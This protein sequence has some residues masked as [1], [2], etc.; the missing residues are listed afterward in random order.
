MTSDKPASCKRCRC[1]LDREGICHRCAYQMHSSDEC[2]LPAG[3][4]DAI[5]AVSCCKPTPEEARYEP[6]AC[7]AA[8]IVETIEGWAFKHGAR[9]EGGER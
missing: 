8:Q 5:Y 7:V 3:I 6:C 1:F 4:K 9:T 2:T